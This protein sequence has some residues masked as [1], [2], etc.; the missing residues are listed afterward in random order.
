[1]TLFYPPDR[2]EHALRMT[3]GGVHDEHVNADLHERIYARFQVAGGSHG[4]PDAKA[5]KLIAIG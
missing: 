2:I 1:M 4:G 3:V 5:P